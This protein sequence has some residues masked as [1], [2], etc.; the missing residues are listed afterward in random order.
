MIVG[1]SWG[2]EEYQQQVP[3][4]GQSGQEL[5]RMLQEA[6]LTANEIFYTNVAP[7]QPFDNDM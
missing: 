4:V 3:F 6:Q 7:D 5:I 2:I 1:E